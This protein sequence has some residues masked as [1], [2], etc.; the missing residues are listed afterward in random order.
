MDRLLSMRVFER[1]VG[2]GGFAA[3]ARA[4]DMSAP[5]VTRLV[6]DLEEH[7]GTR[8]LQRTTR[9]L[10]MTDAGQAYLL[11]VHNILQEIDEAH[12]VASSHTTELAG[13]LRLH[14]PPVLASYV[15]APLLAEFRRRHPKIQI[16]IEVETSKEPPI[17][18]YDIT[19]LGTDNSFDGDVVARKVIESEAILVASPDYLKR[20]GRLQVPEDLSRHECL[21]LKWPGGQPR[22]WRMWHPEHPEQ[23]VEVDVQPILLANHTDT[24][25]RATLDGAGITSVSVDLVAPHLTRGELVRVLSPWITG[26]LALYAALPSRK[27]IPQRTRI[28]LDYLVKE[29][30]LQSTKALEACSA[31]V[32]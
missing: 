15:I 32:G 24:L 21:R 28:F 1:V 16:D 18:D 6:A 31:Y 26:R 13:L 17:E 4:L 5:V 25:L 7:L 2:E 23:V 3:A 9:R 22:T 20:R 14:A 27:F 19:L 8:L 10:S 11:R 30:Q 29:T 12:A